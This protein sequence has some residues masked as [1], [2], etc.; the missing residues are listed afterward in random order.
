MVLFGGGNLGLKL[1]QR[2]DTVEEGVQ[3][4]GLSDGFCYDGRMAITY[5]QGPTQDNRDVAESGLV[6]IAF[7]GVTYRGSYSVRA[8]GNTRKRS[9][10]TPDKRV[11]VSYQGRDRGT[12]IGN[13]GLEVM[14]ATLLQ[15]LVMYT[16]SSV[17]TAR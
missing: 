10:V 14:A 16:P 11:T 4:P 9:T 3:L 1:P 12:A 7:A 8:E 5:R 6:E 15:E 17:W 13:S 2:F